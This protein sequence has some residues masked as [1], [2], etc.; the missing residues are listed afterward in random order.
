MRRLNWIPFVVAVLCSHAV[1]AAS[2]QKAEMLYEHGLVDDAKGE[3]IEVIFERGTVAADK[4][5]ALYLLGTIAF[6]HDHVAL[7]LRTWRTLIDEHPQSQPAQLVKGR[8]D[9]LAGIVG[10]SVRESVDNAVALSYLRHGDFWSRGKSPV[11]TIDSSWIPNVDS[12]VK[13]YGRVI[14]EF[15]GTTA[16]RVALEGKMR[17]LIGWKE[18]G[19]YGSKHGLSEDFARYMPVLIGTFNTYEAD[20]PDAPSLQAFRYQIAQG[21]WKN[22]D[23][24]G[25]RQWLQTIIAKAGDNDSF[26]K[27]LATR[28]LQKVEY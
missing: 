4:A 16:A 3:L 27:D 14:Q 22:Q 10:E 2:I 17:T 21:Y 24:E 8:I 26:Y 15:P 20:F 11:L 9:E 7:A 28:R 18:P 23:W 25:T 1:M 13:W 6:E 19:Q 5:N 12:S